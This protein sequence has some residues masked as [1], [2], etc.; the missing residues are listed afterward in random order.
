LVYAFY[1]HSRHILKWSKERAAIIAVIGFAVVIFTYI[2]VNLGLTG[3]G[4]HV[5]GSR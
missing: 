2:G 3:S 5:Y 1:L 4:L